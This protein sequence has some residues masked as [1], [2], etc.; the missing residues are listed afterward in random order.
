MKTLYYSNINHLFTLSLRKRGDL[1]LPGRAWRVNLNSGG[2][3]LWGFAERWSNGVTK[4]YCA[5]CVCNVSKQNH[6]SAPLTQRCAEHA[7]FIFKLTFAAWYLQIL[8]H[9]PYIWLKCNDLL[10]INSSSLWQIPWHSALNC[11]L[12]ISTS[13][14]FVNAHFLQCRV[15]SNTSVHILQ[16]AIYNRSFVVLFIVFL[17]LSG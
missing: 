2:V 10:L 11:N 4:F 15:S 13:V 14:T 3:K 7:G 12:T 1:S 9:I 17:W 16:T 5:C 6:A 8:V